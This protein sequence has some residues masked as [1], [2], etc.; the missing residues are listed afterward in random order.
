MN[1]AHWL[2]RAGLS[3]GER[4]AVGSGARVIRTYRGLA[5]RAA[6]LAGASDRHQGGTAVPGKVG[7]Q[8]ADGIGPDVDRPDAHRVFGAGASHSDSFG[9]RR[10]R[11]SRMKGLQYHR[12]ALT[13]N[14]RRC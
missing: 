5:E 2:E 8:Q 14:D 1:I 3:H 10:C 6:R 13:A 12:G 9:W 11:D 7:H 4:P